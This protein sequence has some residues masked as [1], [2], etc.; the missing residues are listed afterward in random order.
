MLRGQVIAVT[1]TRDIISGPPGGIH[2]GEAHDDLI[3]RL[4]GAPAEVE[5]NWRWARVIISANRPLTS[6]EAL[7]EE[8]DT[9][10]RKLAECDAQR[11]SL[12][13]K[14]IEKVA[15]LALYEGGKNFDAWTVGTSCGQWFALLGGPSRVSLIEVD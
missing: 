14:L 1:H 12:N 15:R 5:H 10:R 8:R 11:R 9:L 2:L 4:E 6:L 13:G 3:V 7:E